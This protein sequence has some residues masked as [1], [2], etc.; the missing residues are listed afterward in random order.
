MKNLYKNAITML[1]AIAIATIMMVTPTVADESQLH[2]AV[3]E[4]DDI[5]TI[6]AH[7]DDAPMLPQVVPSKKDLTS[8][9]P[10]PGDQGNQGSCTAWAVA[11]ALK[12][13]LETTKREWTVNTNT[14]NFS[15]SF[16]YNQLTSAGGGIHIS[17]AMNLVKNT[18]IC[19]L[20]YFPYDESD[21]STQPSS[22]VIA[23]ANLYK[24][25]NWNTIEGVNTI[26]NYI[27]C[28]AGVV[29]AIKVYPD[30]DNISSS[31]QIYDS[32]AGTSRGAHA[33]C[34]IGYD[35]SKG[36]FKFINSWGD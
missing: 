7:L 12:S 1:L 25:S 19:S 34:L 3:L 5:E 20:N 24:A 29:I 36:A 9:F 22:K 15:P 21:Y 23:A 28:G 16:V 33:I 26:K 35:D 8:I 10:T 27:A 6:N 2:P 30:F 31:N 32:S 4:W 18:G 14:H 17:D 11:Y 13:S